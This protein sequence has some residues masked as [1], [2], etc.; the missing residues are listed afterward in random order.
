MPDK[1]RKEGTGLI[2]LRI[3][4]GLELRIDGNILAGRTEFRFNPSRQ[5]ELFE[6]SF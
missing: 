4:S 2:V 3:I 5:P 6:M 1:L